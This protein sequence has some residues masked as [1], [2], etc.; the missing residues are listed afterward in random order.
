[1]NFDGV[2]LTPA[3]AAA[4]LAMRDAYQ[5]SAKVGGRTSHTGGTAQRALVN[6]RAANGLGA[7]GM[8]EPGR[9]RWGK[10]VTLT[11]WGSDV[12]DRLLG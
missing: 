4:L 11:P 5:Q 2:T 1:M 10:Y 12:A 3:Q 8:V 9:D 7:L 6:G